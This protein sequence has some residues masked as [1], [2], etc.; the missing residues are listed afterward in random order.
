MDSQDRLW[1]PEQFPIEIQSWIEALNSSL[2]DFITRFDAARMPTRDVLMTEIMELKESTPKDMNRVL[3]VLAEIHQAA[4]KTSV[5]IRCGPVGD[6]LFNQQRV[7]QILLSNLRDVQYADGEAILNRD[8]KT[9]L[10]TSGLTTKADS[11]LH[12]S[13]EI[14]LM[15]AA[16][17]WAGD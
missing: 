9:I 17:A 10:N 8:E 15:L 12:T 14:F 1:N 4:E 7:V 6:A 16:K 2:K 13:I 5:T 11:M 3:S